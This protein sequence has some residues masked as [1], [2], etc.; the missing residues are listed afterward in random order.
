[1]EDRETPRMHKY[2][3]SKTTQI[4]ITIVPYVTALAGR[5]KYHCDG[6]LFD[7]VYHP[8]QVQRVPVERGTI[9]QDVRNHA[10]KTVGHIQRHSIPRN[11]TFCP[12]YRSPSFWIA[13][14]ADGRSCRKWLID[15]CKK[16]VAT[17]G[18]SSDHY[19][20]RRHVM[21]GNNGSGFV[22]LW[23]I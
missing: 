15:T 19:E 20:E 5:T 2:G 10:I 11:Y 6:F 14:D 21:C 13:C 23:C 12:S 18:I 22:K 8:L 1:M 3:E 7:W 16:R 9:H 17:W 4:L